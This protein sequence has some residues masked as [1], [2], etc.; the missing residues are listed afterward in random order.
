MKTTHTLPVSRKF[1]ERM[2]AR[3][4]DVMNK[5]GMTSVSLNDVLALINNYL[6]TREVPAV[7]PGPT[8]V[9]LIVFFSLK[10]EIDAAILRSQRARERAAIRR[11]SSFSSQ[12]ADASIPIPSDDKPTPFSATYPQTPDTPA[13]P[14]PSPATHARGAHRDRWLCTSQYLL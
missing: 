3:I 9:S 2:S 13:P 1:M 12:R 5:I 4:T 6:L 11:R 7:T 8:A 14:S 10:E